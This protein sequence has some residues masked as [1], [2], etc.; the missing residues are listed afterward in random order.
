ML[1][2]DPLKGV[3]GVDLETAS[4]ADLKK[5]GQ[6]AYAEHE[7]TRVYCVVFGY[8]EREGFYT[9]VQW[10]PG[11]DLP[12]GL[13]EYLF[14]GGTL[15]AHNASF[16]ASIWRVI[17]ERVSFPRVEL[18]QWTDT[19]V[20]GLALNLPMALGGLAKA[21]GCPIKK[22]EV[23]AALMR[24][25]MNLEP[26]GR[27]G[28]FNENDTPKNRKRL[29]A[30]CKDDVGAMLDA[31][32]KLKPLDVRE[33]LAYE[34]DKKIN[35]RGVCLDL[36]L[37]RSCSRLVKLR[38]KE[39]DGE[40][41]VGLSDDWRNMLIKDARNPTA[42][43]NF[44]EEHGV[45]VP[46]RT[47]KKIDKATGKAVYKKTASTDKAAVVEM[48]AD[49]LLHPD[50]KIV[51]ENR[52]ES[53]KATSLAKLERVPLMVGVDGRLRYALQFLAA[54]TGRWSS[55][56]LQ[57]HNLPKDKLGDLGAAVLNAIYAGDLEGLKFL[58]DRPLEAVSQTLRS[59]IVAPEGRE[60]VA[61]DYSAIEAR[62]NA[63]LSGQED[64]LELFRSGVCVYTRAAH[65]VGS[66][67]R[68]LGK[69]CVLALG[70]GMGVVTFVTTAAGW[71]IVLSLKEARRIQRAWRK[72][73]DKIVAFWHKLEEAAKAAIAEPGCPFYAGKIKAIASK[74]CLGLVLPSGRV[75]RYWKPSI[76]TTEKTIKM[77]DEEGRIFEK[78]MA[79][80]EIRFFS[81]GSDKKSM[82]SES[83][84]GGKL[85]ENVVQAIARDL[86]AEAS[87]RVD[88]V[89][90]YDLV[91]HVHDSLVAEVP[92]GAG[93]VREFC[94]LISI[95]PPWAKGL[96]LE[97]DG[98]R[99][100]RFR[101]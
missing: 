14:A 27:G 60:L 12:P 66:D 64:I 30:Y 79:G 72:A 24:S 13:V 52:R 86:L 28:W 51:L 31:Y 70:Y 2:M 18:D 37:A 47:R 29:L 59:L 33:A 22:D 63:W 32:F 16:E 38:K 42:L 34:V 92:R 55:S 93:D 46:T 11:D 98:Y 90:P 73:N 71:G 57:V 87:V 1:S 50:V 4:A 41:L 20:L 83:T 69:V 40:V 35:A 76:V 78:V 23:G 91:M 94:E 89:E 44:L 19:Q 7:S 10:E 81:M 49:P 67:D 21:L 62:V 97:A 101:G 6:W 100:V 3:L 56:G 80:E 96:P 39:L 84:Y 53:T 15:I 82:S 58:A 8:A 88:R 85:A 48:L 95:L 36:E 61:G 45:D 68:Q 17:L 54:S 74:A 75:L 77:V 65:D 26:D 9:F 25:M 5:V 99:D 43:K